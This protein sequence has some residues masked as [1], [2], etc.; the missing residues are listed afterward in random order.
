MDTQSAASH[1]SAVRSSEKVGR[2]SALPLAGQI[3]RQLGMPESWPNVQAIKLAI[4]AEAGYSDISIAQAAA[5]IVSAAHDFTIVRP[6]RYN[7]QAAALLRK[8]NVIN[9]FWFED[10]LWRYKDAYH[11]LLH[12]LQQGS[13]P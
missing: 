6:D 3:A 5:L 2:N 7:F 4:L 10:S 13:N 9:R 11:Q 1:N 12:R 8:S